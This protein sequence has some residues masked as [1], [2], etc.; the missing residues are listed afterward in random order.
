MDQTKALKA[1][2][3]SAFRKAMTDI[4]KERVVVAQKLKGKE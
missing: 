2:P 3:A 1:S 4:N